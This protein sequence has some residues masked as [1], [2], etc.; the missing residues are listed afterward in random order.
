MKT[1]ECNPPQ[2]QTENIK[3]HKIISIDVEKALGKNPIYFMTKG[4]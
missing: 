2:K 1:G 4:L 3:H